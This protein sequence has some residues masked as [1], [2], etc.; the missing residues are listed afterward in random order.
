MALNQQVAQ[1]WNTLINTGNITFLTDPAAAVTPASGG[2]GAFKQLRANAG[3]AWWF[4]GL[5]FGNLSAAGGTRFDY[6]VNR[7]ADGS[8]TNICAI[9]I[10]ME[11]ALAVYDQD[12]MLPYPVRVAAA[13]GAAVQQLTASGKTLDVACQYGLA[14]GT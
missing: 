14:I 13:V 12:R 3:A 6:G 10:I 4:V 2:P 7:L 9:T 11:A 5:I 8:G 1:V